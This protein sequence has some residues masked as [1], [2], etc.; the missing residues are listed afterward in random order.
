VEEVLKFA[1]LGLAVGAI[2]AIAAQ[3]L[4]VVYRGSGVL[5]F[6]HGAMALLGAALYMELLDNDA[7]KVVAVVVP[8]L[9]MAVVG[10]LI[11]L[12][13]MRP[14]RAASA[15]ARLVAT[16]GI[17]AVVSSAA[18]IRYGS[19]FQFVD[20]FLPAKN[21]TL[22]GDVSVGRDRLWIIA[23][24]VVMTAVLTV[25]Y[26]TTNFGRATAAVSENQRSAA[27]LGVSPDVVATA[28]WALGGALAA[29]AGI[30]IVPITGFAPGTLALVIVPVLASAMVGGF[31]SFALT[32]LGGAAIGIVQSEMTRYV[33]VTGW[34]ESAP[35][36]VIIGLLVVRGQALPLRGF[37]NDRLPLVA[38]VRRRR[39]TA[40]TGLVLAAVLIGAGSDGLLAA[41]VLTFAVGLIALSVVVV[42][43][44]AGQVSL[45]Q[46]GLA[47]VGAFVSA[48]IAGDLWGLPF[49]L[50]LPI[51]VLAA[52]PFGL[53][54]ALP[55]LRT[56]GV[57]LAIATLG[58]AV[59]L[60]ALLFNNKDYTGGYEG[61]VIDP[62]ALFG[63][64]IDSVSYPQRYAAVAL[65]V[66]TLFAFAVSNLRRGRSGRRLLA[67][68]ANERAA[69]SLGISIVGAK[70]YAFSLGA[71]I[72]AAGGVLLAFRFPNVDFAQY[73]VFASIN[74]VVLTFLGGIGFIGGAL[75]GGLL[76]VG[77]LIPYVVEQYLELGQWATLIT[78][79]ALILMVINDPNGAVFRQML[80]KQSVLQRF[81]R[82]QKSQPAVGT[83]EEITIERAEPRT[84][85]VAGLGMRFG[86]VT[87]LDDVALQ[88]R[89]GEIVGLIG[90]NGAGK[91]TL[92]DAVTGFTKPTT[93]RITLDERD[94]TALSARRRAEL[95]IGRSFQN[96]ELFEDLTVQDNL[97]V[98]AE[99]RDLTSYFLDLFRPSKPELSAAARRAVI[100]FQLGND[101]LKTPTEL[102]Y[103]KR[104]LVAIARS[105]ARHPSV[106]LL[107]EPAAGLDET[108]S[109]ELGQL[110]RRLADDW[111]TAIL[112]VEHDMG[113][114]ME[115]CDR[116]VV[117][118]FGR[119]IADGTPSEVGADPAVISAYLGQQKS[120]ADGQDSP[121]VPTALST[122]TGVIA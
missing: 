55:A 65:V 53:V 27:A 94:I 34:A 49:L 67:T 118:D 24:A 33:S 113:L 35:F 75:F 74:A 18:Q 51:G 41:L 122:S 37:L 117:L 120:A 84:L 83:A 6:S 44:Y 56:R 82:K 109:R 14:L 96:L 116:V 58:L 121:S 4:V 36:L 30:L 1:I 78:G 101:L 32:A 107:D 80:L 8:V 42:T 119:K 20:G 2:Y 69:A 21:T 46:Y 77:G 38:P 115:I 111:G 93:G 79:I 13:I 60:Q 5:N 63:W 59:A 50:A 106:L 17:L 70:L 81:G 9:V 12:L 19:E 15:L 57:N 66:F 112:L 54:F 86:G 43:G 10:V 85:G 88:A 108:E 92:I 26:R 40:L 29:V 89:P 114:V 68:R 25:V 31:S 45:A 98:A 52:I 95:G 28:N 16:L 103:G 23:I 76:V 64:S 71:G 110:L 61:T 87:A 97:C 91:T 3:G 104:R 39:W 22:F 99:K 48:R 102:S 62:P 11:S 47:G 7:P 72:A 90:P 73:D 100:D 105:V